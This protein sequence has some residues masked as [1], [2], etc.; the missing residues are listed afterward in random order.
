MTHNRKTMIL[1]SSWAIVRFALV[2]ARSVALVPL[3]LSFWDTELYTFWVLLLTA[4]ALWFSVYD[5]YIR[6]VTNAYNL[7]FYNEKEKGERILGSGIKFAVAASFVLMALLT[8]LV[9]A[10][11]RATG[12]VFKAGITDVVQY[13]LGLAF[14]AFIV[15]NTFLNLLRFFYALNDPQGKLWRNLRFEVLYSIAEIL[16]LVISLMYVREFYLV[17]TINALLYVVAA[18]IFLISLRGKYPQL[19]AIVRNGNIKEGCSLLRLSMPF[20]GNNFIEKL[21]TDSYT[22]L[23]SFFAWPALII[24]QFASV[25]TMTNA[26]ISGMNI[27]QTVTA[28]RIQEHEAK[29]NNDA[30]LKIFHRLWLLAAFLCGTLLIPAYPLLQRVYLAWTKGKIAFDPLVFGLLFICL[31][32]VLFGNVLLYYLKSVN[33]TRTV[34]VATIVK[35]VLLFSLLLLLPHTAIYAV[36]DLL[37]AEVT[38]NILLYP[39]FVVRKW[40]R[41]DGKGRLMEIVGGLLPFLLI[42]GAV[43]YYLAFGFSYAIAAVAYVML[44]GI[45]FVFYRRVTF[46]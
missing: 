10:F 7:Y 37:V 4:N 20:I 43:S 17:V 9:M 36:A 31:L 32:V 28:P 25:R 38:A 16:V 42:A 8:I 33:E 21:A 12:A 15:G 22:L 35:I 41:E 44:L 3:I 40:R 24:Q 18:V 2:F 19:P 30:L 23:L 5:G 6:Y 1:G 46:S 27:F 29:K 39:I 34:L 14:L 26:G 45:L 13:R 11:P